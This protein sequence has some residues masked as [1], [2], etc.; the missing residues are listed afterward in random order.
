[1][2]IFEDL[3]KIPPPQEAR[4]ANKY[5]PVATISM[6]IFELIIFFA[7]IFVLSATFEKIVICLLFL[8]YDHMSGTN[9]IKD[10][11]RNKKWISGTAEMFM[12][13]S[14]IIP[15]ALVLLTLLTIIFLA[16]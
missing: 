8:I 16:L 9:A 5:T 14:A 3:E 4:L 12:M 7:I 1:M 11:E 13:L 2:S 15:S 10:M 6:A